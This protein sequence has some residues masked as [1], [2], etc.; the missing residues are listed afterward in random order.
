MRSNIHTAVESL[1][2][3]LSSEFNEQESANGR[4]LRDRL[5]A[6]LV[7]LNDS[8]LKHE[9]FFNVLA[10]SWPLIKDVV[11]LVSRDLY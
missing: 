11:E 4:D 9:G 7:L 5:R 8:N 1:K 10:D 3:M 6:A 2:R